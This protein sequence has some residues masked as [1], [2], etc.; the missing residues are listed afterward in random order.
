[1]FYESCLL[2]GQTA[3]MEYVRLLKKD[4]L[5]VDIGAQR[6]ESEV[7]LNYITIKLAVPNT[8]NGNVKSHA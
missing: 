3:G 1:M 7:L 2:L 5:L 4:L 8:D 6:L